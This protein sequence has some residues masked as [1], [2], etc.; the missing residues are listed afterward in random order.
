MPRSL[1]VSVKEGRNVLSTDIDDDGNAVG[2]GEI[3]TEFALHY[4]EVLNVSPR[5]RGDLTICNGMGGA[6]S[7]ASL[8][9]LQTWLNS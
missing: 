5:F 7:K 4:I 6:A 3:I 1:I 2:Q 9:V 8:L